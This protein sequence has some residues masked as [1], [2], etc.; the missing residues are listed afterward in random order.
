MALNGEQGSGKTT[1]AKMVRSLI[2]P[3][4]A[5]LRGPP[6]DLRDLA[7]AAFNQYVLAF[8]NLSGISA[9]LADALCRLST[10]GGFATRMLYSKETR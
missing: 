10:G 9:D 8:D 4:V 6:R 1:A 5:P 7:I 2:D 3:H